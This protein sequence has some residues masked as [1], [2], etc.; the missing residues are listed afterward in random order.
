MAE[1]KLSRLKYTWLGEWTAYGRYNPDDI[2]SYGG[3]SYVSLETHVANNDFYS[4]L[5]YYNN[6]IPPLLVPKWELVADGTS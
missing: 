3:K 5:N 2:V 1:F 4:D 6:D